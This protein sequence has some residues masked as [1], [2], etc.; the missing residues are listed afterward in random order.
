MTTKHIYVLNICLYVDYMLNMLCLSKKS[1][2]IVSVAQGRIKE[3][4]DTV[5]AENHLKF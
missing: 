3:G 2:H 5:Y 4:F 1:R